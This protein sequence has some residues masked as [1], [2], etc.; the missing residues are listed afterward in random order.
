MIDALLKNLEHRDTL[1]QGERDLLQGTILRA[2]RFA[3]GE[4]I[5]SEGS[6]PSYS[7]L[8][9]DGLAARYKVTREGTRQ[10]T[11]LHIPGDFVDLHAFLMKTLDHSIVA[12][13]PCTV[14]LADHGQ[15]KKITE[16]APH[17]ARLLWLD[18]LVTGSIHRSWIVAMGRRSKSSHLAH[19]LCEL[20]VRLQV[21]DLVED[22]SFHFPLS[23]GEMADVMGL[24][25]VHMNRVIQ[26]LR[27]EKVI[28][29][30]NQRITVLDWDRLKE[31]A[32]FDPAYLN[33]WIEPR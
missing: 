32:E 11:A 28:A 31:I 13:S 2:R 9:T 15:L 30:A 5:V 12:L 27:R 6:R 22:K 21:V 10:I 14:F 3:K 8:L 19:I 23:Q 4:D 17:L 24:S 7:T 18:T 29:W 1:S 20:Y 16:D 25:L 33:L 26:T